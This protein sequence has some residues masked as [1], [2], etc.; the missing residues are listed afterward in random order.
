MDYVRQ[1]VTW[2]GGKLFAEVIALLLV[3]GLV[4]FTPFRDENFEIQLLVVGVIIFV[5]V[6]AMRA[7]RRRKWLFWEAEE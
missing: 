5:S 3:V 2:D 4:L 1:F 7:F 6:R